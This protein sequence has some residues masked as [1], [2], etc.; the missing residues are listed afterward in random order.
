MGKFT[1]LGVCIALAFT[2][3]DAAAQS[4]PKRGQDVKE[5]EQERQ[6]A[7]EY[8][9]VGERVGSFKFLPT[10][11][12]DLE[13]GTN[14]FATSTGEQSDFLTR[15]RPGVAFNSDWNNHQLNLTAEAEAVRHYRFNDDDVVNYDYGA[16]GR[17]D[18]LRSL[19]ISFGAGYAQV[20]EGRGDPNAVSTAKSPT[21]G[22]NTTANIGIEYKPN[23]LS[24]SLD[25]TYKE[26]DLDDDINRDGSVT[27]NDD[28]D[29]EKIELT[30]RLGYEY[31]ENTEA[32][33]KA[34][35][36]KISYV[37]SFD[38]GGANRSSD[39]YSVVLGTGL[40][41]TGLVTGQ[42]FAGYISQSND[43]LVLDD[44]A[45]PTLGA[46]VDWSA[47]P[48]ISIRG[49]VARSIQESTTDGTAGYVSTST[50]ISADYE[51]LRQLT[52]SAELDW[53]LDRYD[54]IGKEDNFYKTVIGL[55]YLLNRYVS[56]DMKNTFKRKTSN[57]DDAAYTQ[58]TTMLTLS[59]QF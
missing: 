8:A 5:R 51:I 40:D 43:D 29:K 54:R 14:L 1:A 11:D 4:A 6:S 20:H 12:A 52:A 15:V 7:D 34:S 26:D 48:L 22:T 28:R 42:V 46:T 3:A 59:G 18:V 19:N 2:I 31:L 36:N 38:D 17:V 53:T 57:S 25:A 13:Y 55:K 16:N 9:A 37:S 45:A 47:T 41:F 44:I 39:G 21:A 56:A 35:S 30:A 27:N 24:L 49:N 33:L 32:F 10:I 23:K 50:T 58:N